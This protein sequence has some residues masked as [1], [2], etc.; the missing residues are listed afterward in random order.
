M[1]LVHNESNPMSREYYFHRA[2]TLISKR[3]LPFFRIVFIS[4]ILTLSSVWAVTAYF[5][6]SKEQ[7]RL[8]SNLEI[9]VIIKNNTDTTRIVSLAESLKNYEQIQMVKIIS[10]TLAT[11][12]FEK[13]LGEDTDALFNESPFQWSIVFT[14]KPEYCN[15][16]TVSSILADLGTKSII[17]QAVFN[18]KAAGA[19]F[20]RS[21]MVLALGLAGATGIIVLFLGFL[22]YVFRSE[23]LQSPAEWFILQTLGAGRMFIAFPHVLFASSA[24]LIGIAFGGCIAIP[25]QIASSGSQPWVMDVPFVSIMSAYGTVALL[26]L[27]TAIITA[28]SV[29]KGK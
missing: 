15:H 13:E 21:T 29:S 7:D 8:A 19:L 17:E 5:G 18:D 24:C 2:G 9:S 1:G 12:E 28:F 6:I 25:I 10:P 3:K 22:S 11:I 20:A 14:M 27:S 23:L 4:I 16:Q 26:S